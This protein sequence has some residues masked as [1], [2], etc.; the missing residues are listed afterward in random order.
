[1]NDSK[2]TP[3]EALPRQDDE[4]NVQMEM[5]QEQQQE[6]MAQPPQ[7][8]QMQVQ[9]QPPPMYMPPPPQ[10]QYQQQRKVITKSKNNSY[11]DKLKNI[12]F[13]DWKKLLVLTLVFF[14]VQSETLTCCLRTLVRMAKV[15]D[16]MVFI[17]SKL[18][19]SVLGALIYLLLQ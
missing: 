7:P 8:Q 2:A 1:M 16:N 14:V 9:Y 15:S 12:I 18:L 10:Q 5:Q 6:E 4:P 13:S 3:L 19:G 17:S 11:I